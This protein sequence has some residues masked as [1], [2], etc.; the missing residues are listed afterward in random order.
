M[1]TFKNL[2]IILL[3]FIFISNISAQDVAKNIIVEHFT[4]TR[5]GICA[6]RNPA[7]YNAL[8]QNPDVIHIAY[9]PSAPYS[10][11]LFST[12]NKAQNDARTRFYNVFGSTPRFIINGDERSGNQVANTMAY[13]DFKNQTTPVDLRVNIAKAGSEDI[14][15]SFGVNIKSDNTIGNVNYFITLVE[16][17]VLYDAPNGEKIHHD[18]FRKSLSNDVLPTFMIPQNVG[19]EYNFTT[20]I[21]T[22]SFWDVSRIYAIVILTDNN[23][24]VVQA[25]RSPL[26]NPNILSST[27][28][29]SELEND[30]TIYPNPVQNELFFSSKQRESIQKVNIKNQV[31]Q[32]IFELHPK[33]NQSSINTDFL[34]PGTYFL[35]VTIENKKSVQKFIKI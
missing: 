27:N 2:T 15:I 4:N 26:Y 31:G 20:K 25:A 19:N 12:Q 6:N 3:G 9:H 17:T 18:V 29:E 11:C 35:E 34:T 16:D 24:K 1:N 13:N 30:V 28:N 21:K 10:S 8:H 33:D 23:K 22:E 7:F 5:C 32:N 14:E